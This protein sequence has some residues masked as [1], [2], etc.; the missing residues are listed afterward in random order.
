M[1]IPIPN[2]D[3]EQPSAVIPPP[4]APVRVRRRYAGVL[5]LLVLLAAVG[6]AAFWVGQQQ[7]QLLRDTQKQGNLIDHLADNVS[8][9]EAKSAE[10]DTRQRDFA[11]VAQ[12]NGAE[13]ADFGRRIDEHDQIVGNLN[14]QMAGGRN[15]FLM[16]SIENLLLLANDRLQIA[17]DV[18]SAQ[19]ALQ[20]ADARIGDLRDPRL[21]NVRQAIAE[22]RAAL[23]QVPEPDYAGAA[24]T[25]SSLAGRVARLPLR[26]RAPDHFESTVAAQAAPAAQDTRW[27]RLR[28]AV[29]Q[30]L[31][32][33]FTLRRNEGPA[34]RLL[35]PQEEALVHQVLMLRLEAARVALLRGDTVSFRDS[36]TAAARWL[37]D[38]F[39]AEDPAVQAALAELERL[40]PLELAPPLPDISRSL[41]LLRAHM[42]VPAR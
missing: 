7:T 3:A 41:T 21:F 36:C 25:L 38:Y 22:E 1:S 2:D 18:N 11:G 24:L 34:A 8:K 6:A 10:L 23:Q 28:A 15:R 19:V 35:A 40:Q 31:R 32:G 16:A 26:A 14:E 37:R 17:H 5:L 30:A 12:R 27:Q 13:I 33:M 29:G 42:D 9:L 20:E 4:S 39:R